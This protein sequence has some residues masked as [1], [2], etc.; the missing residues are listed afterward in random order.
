MAQNQNPMMG[1]PMGPVPMGAGRGLGLPNQFFQGPQTP[2]QVQAM[3]NF[4]AGRPQMPQMGGGPQGWA[5]GSAGPSMDQLLGGGMAPALGPQG[6]LGQMAA[7]QMAGGAPGQG[8]GGGKGAGAGA[9]GMAPQ[10]QKQIAA[11]QGGPGAMTTGLYRGPRPGAPG[12]PP[13]MLGGG[14]RPRR[15]GA[16]GAGPGGQKPRGMQQQ[17]AQLPGGPR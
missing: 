2:A 8:P 5:Q 17:M 16:P 14:M 11:L 12:A 13:G 6:K 10:M 15:P 9:Q 4:G 1:Q 7:G 3:Q